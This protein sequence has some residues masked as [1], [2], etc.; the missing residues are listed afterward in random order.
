MLLLEHGF[1]VTQ[2]EAVF[3]DSVGGFDE[4]GGGGGNTLGFCN[5]LSG[6]DCFGDGGGDTL[7]RS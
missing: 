6:G 1:A 5:W 7:A 2:G 3:S 4:A